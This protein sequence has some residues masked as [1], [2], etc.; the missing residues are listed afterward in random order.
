MTKFHVHLMAEVR[1]KVPNVEADSKEEA[2]AKAMEG[3]DLNM[4]LHREV[5]NEMEYAE[6]VTGALVDEAEDE[7][8]EKS[9]YFEDK[10]FQEIMEKY[11]KRPIDVEKRN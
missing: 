4:L 5:P 11:S 2:V 9:Q 10:K 1:I 3:I 7:S 6:A 8:F